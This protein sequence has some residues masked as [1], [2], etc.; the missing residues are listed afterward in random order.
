MLDI[1]RAGLDR[2]RAPCLG[3]L[4]L[5]L[6]LALAGCSGRNA[7]LDAEDESQS[8][9]RIP[10]SVEIEGADTAADPGLAG[11]L[12]SAS[13][14]AASTD[15][16]PPSILILRNRAERDVT[17]LEAALHSRG[18]YDGTVDFRIDQDETARQ[19]QSGGL[20]GEIGAMLTSPSTRIVFEVDPGERYMF[21]ERSIRVEGDPSGLT[22]PRAA[23][24]GL[25]RGEP[26]QAE[27]VVA[28]EDNLLR[29]AWRRGHPMAE[30]ADRRAV[31]DRDTHT[32]DVELAIRPGPR[33]RFAK[34]V[35]T[36]ETDV[37]PAFL[38]QRLLIEPGTRYDSR[39]VDRARRRLVDT[40]LFSTVQVIE[41]PEPN[42]DGDW[43]ITFE[44]SERLPRTIGAGVGYRS[45]D[46]P[47]VRAFWEHRNI[48]GAGERLRIEAET[49]QILQ[50][51]EAQ[52]LKPDIFIPDLDL[53][54][55]GA[56]RREETD[57]FDS[58]SVRGNIGVERR[59]SR[60]L[61]G[62]TGVAYR[63]SRV[64]DQ[65]TG[66]EDTFGLLSVPFGLRYD[67]SDDLLD[68]TTGF[69]IRVETAPTWDTLNPSTKYVKNRVVGSRYFRIHNK[70]RFVLALRAAAGAIVG[71]EID[72][73]PA[74]ERFYAG[75]GGSIRGI[76]FQTAGPLDGDT[77]TGGRSLLEASIEARYQLFEKVEGAVFLDGGSA[78]E[79]ELPQFGDAWQFGTG[80]GLR[81]L[82]PVG[83]IRLDV[84]VPV[85]RRKNVDDAWQLYISIGQAF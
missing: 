14:A 39:D 83:P 80:V 73:I 51:L 54:G 12:R 42:A 33:L 66:D 36:G 22:P 59:F 7:S 70:P 5:A 32:M 13:N 35:V 17:Q 40:N 41:G 15:R 57:A 56:L 24:L 75:G 8:G 77:P 26:A 78:F 4:W 3:L 58:L 53:L 82:T 20:T 68:P 84:A 72:E 37:D 23:E 30:I 61:T 44:V 62:S 1:A 34:P 27:T 81:Y 49:S 45:E 55:G 79:N 29:Y 85:D 10:Y 18:F 74:D 31:I 65:E 69:R 67:A 28:A 43:P 76:P 46:G 48:F 9:P 25:K 2:A 21:D 6:I 11:F 16:P 63:L 64:Q 50:R 19:T 38:Q 71:A 60:R 47:V 52:L